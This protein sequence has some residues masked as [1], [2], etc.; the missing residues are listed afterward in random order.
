MGKIAPLTKGRKKSTTVK[1]APIQWSSPWTFVAATTG[2]VVWLN[3]FSQ[4]PYLSGQY[5]GSAFLIVYLVGVI[6]ISLPL[7][8]MEIMIG[9]RGGQSPINA[10]KRIA[11]EEGLS[12][13]WSWLGAIGMLTGFL[14]FAYYSV[15][16][17]WT[18]AHAVRAMLGAF[19]GLTADGVSS[20][21]SEFVKD[22]EKQL[23]WYTLFVVMTLA[24]VA[25]NLRKGIEAVTKYVV[26]AMLILLIILVIYAMTL[27]PFFVQSF[28]D[29]LQPDFTKLTT[30]GVLLALGQAFFGSSLGVGALMTYGA[31]LP[32]EG[33]IAKFSIIVVLVD[34]AVAV[35]AGLV[36]FPVLAAGNFI[37]TSGPDLIF[38][39]LPVAFDHLRFGTFFGA[40]FYILLVLV[41]W[42]SSISFVEPSILWLVERFSIKRTQAVWIFGLAAWVFGIVA[43]LS[44]NYWAFSFNFFGAT[45]NIGFF[46][47]LLV[48]T[49]GILMPL[50]SLMLAGFV[51]WKLE[52]AKIQAELNTNSPCSYD[53]WLWLIRVVTPILLVILL[54]NMSKLFL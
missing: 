28:N 32:K 38:Q 49:S 11:Q 2:S 21:F 54:F 3:N 23:F 25:R 10:I 43:L 19:R 51:G 50:G 42:M 44:F 46:D 41:T 40:L 45:K 52:S 9:R 26:P 17:G 18:L 47:I 29:L 37:P 1:A 6:L 12:A 24:V 14:V 36:I 20:H 5:G 48:L 30:D 13:R 35:L 4:F 22:P 39:T 53:A 27:R 15:I 34:L 16:A 7:M 33:S 8:I 31:A